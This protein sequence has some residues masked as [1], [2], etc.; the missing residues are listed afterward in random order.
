MRGNARTTRIAAYVA[1]GA[2]ALSGVILAVTPAEAVVHDPIGANQGASWLESQL[3]N[4]VVHN[5]QFNFDDIGLTADVALALLE[6]GGHAATVTDIV[7]TI[8]PRAQA[9]WY[10]STFGGVTTI[11]SGSI[12]KAL[13][14]AQE[15]GS[16]PTSF[17][18]ANLVTELEARTSA[19]AP[20]AGRIEHVNDSFGD[21]NVIGQAY[22]VHGLAEASSGEAAAA[23]E[24]LLKQQCPSGGFRL[25]FTPSKTDVGQSC[26][27][28]STAETDATAI[29]LQQLSAI[30]T[31]PAITTAKNAARQWLI[32]NQRTDGAWGG[33]PTTEASNANS[34]GLAAWALGD[35]AESEQAAL[36]LRG[37]QATDYHACDKLA[38]E[39]GA[40]AYDSPALF[41]GRTNGITAAKQDQWRR[42]GAQAVPAMEYLPLD[43][44]PS[45]P[46][47]TGPSGYLKAGTNQILVTTGVSSGDQLCIT[48]PLAAIQGT[49]S[50][51][52]WQKA[53]TLPGGTRTR[54]YTVRDSWGHSD[55]VALKV[56]GRTTLAVTKSKNRVKRSGVVTAMVAGLLPNEWARIFYKGRLVRSGHAT[57][58]GK[59][60]AS[61]RVGRALGKKRIVG[62]GQF[63]DIRRGA[64]T[65]KV[66]R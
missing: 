47:L 20:I 58:T 6:L 2:L 50:S 51:T 15:A 26:T 13:V 29:A 12:A 65:V 64:S 14:L 48:G 8:E 63:T 31:T 34:T 41:D 44:T 53:V 38:G 49:A 19:T 36:W 16:D 52:R 57:T 43:T 45:T 60:V 54:V 11:Y 46:V 10:T 40:I 3:T 30:T 37:R 62:Y 9:E 17:G 66:V 56:L 25:A 61:F 27:D 33:G 55:A 23:T 35:T 4:G 32:D 7:N 24:F 22:A 21:A 5:D 18:G 1:S 59:F 39:R 42:A 28:N